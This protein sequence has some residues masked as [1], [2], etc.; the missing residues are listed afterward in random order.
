LWEGVPNYLRELNEQ[1]EENLGYRLPVDFVPVRFTSW[2]G[3]DRDG[4][5]NVTAEITRHV[6]LLSRW[7]AT[8][9][10]LKDIQVLISELSMVEATPELRALAGEEGASEPYRFLM[11]KLRGQLMATQAWLEARLKGQRLPKPEGL[12]SQHEQLWEPL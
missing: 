11:K 4:N 7:K 9:L 8:D 2:M 3:G 1:L 6:L 10:F 5:P 12:L